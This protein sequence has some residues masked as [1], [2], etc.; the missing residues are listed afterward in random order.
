MSSI[1]VGRLD[2]LQENLDLAHLLRDCL[3][4]AITV[5]DEQRRIT[6]FN[7]EAEGLT[8]LKANDLLNHSFELL[9]AGLQDVIGETFSAGQP[10]RDRLMTL[11]TPEGGARELR[12]ST[13]LT[14]TARGKPAAVIVVL[15]DLTSA[16]QLEP[17]LRRLDRLAGIGILATSM[18]H[19]IKNALVAGKTF[20]DLL[21]EKHQDAELAEIVRRELGRI[22]SL[23]SQ[24]LRFAGP[25]KPAFS[26][27]RLHE[28][29]EHSLRLV[30]PQMQIK[31]IALS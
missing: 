4:C 18:A 17:N 3:A 28:V 20:I 7:S 26:A 31:T 1:A 30:Q 13:A 29:L 24:M 12:V 21:L 23:V 22:D 27:V 9:P 19:E 11:P 15:H 8:R 6:A 25:A 16:R 2:V 10:I 14:Q 5:V